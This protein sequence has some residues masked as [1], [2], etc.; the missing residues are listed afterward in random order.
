VAPASPAQ[1]WLFSIGTDG[2]PSVK[3][4]ARTDVIT[5]SLPL[6]SGDHAMTRAVLVILAVLVAPV[7]AAAQESGDIGI[8]MGYPANIGVIYHASD[9]IAIRPE[10]GFSWQSTEDVDDGSNLK[11]TRT[12]LGFGVS[13]LFY[14]SENNNLRTYMS[15]RFA[16]TGSRADIEFSA[17][18]TAETNADSYQLSGSFGAQYSV[19]TK[20]SI[21]GE[22]GIAYSWLEATSFS[23][24]SLPNVGNRDN[25][26][27]KAVGT[28]TAVGVVFYFN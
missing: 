4:A 3:R 23:G 17:S 24:L 9:R 8:A 6:S 5:S 14:T 7:A 1:V 11:E 16:Y 25:D 21:F 22:A 27:G 26:E 2:I 18:Q 20:F 28:R 19:G 10:I 12:S 15:P 13:A